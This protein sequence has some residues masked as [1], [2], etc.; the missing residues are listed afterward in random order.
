MVGHRSEVI[1][2]LKHAKNTVGKKDSPKHLGILM[3]VD[4]WI[5][6]PCFFLSVQ[7]RVFP[8]EAFAI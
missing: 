5:K 2:D 3:F 8:A 1:P 7:E 4:R 6:H